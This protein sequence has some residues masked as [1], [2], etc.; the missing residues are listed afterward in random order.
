MYP[1]RVA[2]SYIYSAPAAN[3][4]SGGQKHHVADRILSFLHI[5]HNDGRA[6]AAAASKAKAKP[7]AAKAKPAAGKAKA[8]PKAT[9]AEAGKKA[10]KAKAAKK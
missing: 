9:K 7:A 5:P 1:T 4:E 6:P 10:G 8:K 3:Y 2:C